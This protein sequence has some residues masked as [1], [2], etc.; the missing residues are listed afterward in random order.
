MGD[1]GEMLG[2]RFLLREW[3]ALAKAAQRGCGC[4]ISGDI[5][6]QVGWSPQQPELVVSN[7]PMAGGLELGDL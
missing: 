7:Q 3:Q 1:L 5:Q 4:P 6:G 2:R